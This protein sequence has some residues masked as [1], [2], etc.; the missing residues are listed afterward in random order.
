MSRLDETLE[1]VLMSS[2][3]RHESAIAEY[4]ETK[5]RKSEHLDVER[6]GDNVVAR[7]TGHHA[8]RVIVAGHLDTVPGDEVAEED[9]D[10]VR[11]V[12]SCD[13]KGSL[14]VMLALAADGAPRSVEV[15]WIFYAREEIARS[16]SGVTWRFS[17]NRRVVA[18]RRDARGHFA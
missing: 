6:V 4:V 2:V 3:S 14:A 7:T 13:M 15:T 9:G 17:L 18:S 16:S 12:G 5:L 8:T 1:L 10:V 11:G